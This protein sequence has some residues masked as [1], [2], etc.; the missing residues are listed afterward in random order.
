M[1]GLWGIF[2]T[3][4]FGNECT[5]HAIMEGARRHAPASR[6]LVICSQPDDTRARH[7]VDA[8]PIA[9]DP[10]SGLIRTRH[11]ESS[12]LSRVLREIRDWGRA[13]RTMRRL[14]H[15][16]IP[17]TGVL[18][19]AHASFLGTP[20]QL[21][22]WTLAARVCGKPVSYV[23][24]GAEML[25]HPVKSRFVGWALRLATYRS[26]RDEGSRARISAL[27][28]RAQR[29]PVYPDLAFSLPRGLLVRARASPRSVAVGIYA[30]EGDTAAVA[31]YVETI[32][33]FLV[34][35]LEAGYQPRVV[36]GDGEYDEAVCRQLMAWIVSKGLR[37]RVVYE[38]ADSFETLMSQIATCDLMVATRFHNVLLNLLFGNPVVSVSHMDKNDQLM[39]MMGLSEFTLPL[40]Q[41]TMAALVERFTRLEVARE[42]LRQRIAA[43]AEEFRDQLEVQYAL[44]FDGRRGTPV[45]GAVRS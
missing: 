30:I 20:Y 6:F 40:A 13:I 9:L 21:L 39:K 23:S 36:Y 33:Q 28:P 44:L 14:D 3:R 37:E 19:D 26:Y 25:A 2:G 43:R 17:G 32:G 15:L 31:R 12:R 11:D 18:S 10:E 35:L 1:I 45:A 27:L 8:V 4:N 41:A 38:H 34:Y 42:S 5:L 29:D 16:V 22:K 7:G 24:V